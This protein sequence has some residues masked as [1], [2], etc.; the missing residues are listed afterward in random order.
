MAR[1]PE[2]GSAAG[3]AN[4]PHMHPRLPASDYRLARDEFQGRLHCLNQRTRHSRA[5]PYDRE[6]VAQCQQ[7]GLRVSFPPDPPNM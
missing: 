3:P 4:A 6:C 5:V 2:Y 1:P 7:Q